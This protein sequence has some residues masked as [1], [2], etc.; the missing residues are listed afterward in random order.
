MGS[1]SPLDGASS[2]AAPGQ[3]WGPTTTYMGA[4]TTSGEAVCRVLGSHQCRGADELTRKL[5]GGQ[6]GSHR[7]CLAVP[8]PFQRISHWYH[9][10]L[11]NLQLGTCPKRCHRNLLA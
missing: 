8:D 3:S 5:P 11:L 10:V 9:R 6:P 1:H 7:T 2:L 4:N